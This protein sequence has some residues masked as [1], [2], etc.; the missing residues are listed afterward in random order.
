MCIT[1]G[2]KFNIKKDRGFTLIELLVAVA[3]FG[4]IGGVAVGVSI[5]GLHAQRKTLASQELLSQ[6]S[7]LMEYMSRT[8]RMAKKEL[9]ESPSCLSER[10][11]NY[12]FTSINGILG[13]KF[14]NSQG[15]CQGFFLDGDGLLK[16]W[17]EG[18]ASPLPLT[19]DDLTVNY[20]NIGP[21]DSWHQDSK[22]Q[23]RVTIFLE[24]E[25]KEQSKIKIQ[26]TISQ[27]DP[28]IIR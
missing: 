4:L 9:N 2:R 24:I 23:P 13:L 6:S 20:F 1:G 16:E 3:V 21:E 22:E 10:G 26:T 17:Q 18:Y 28:N 27:R 7:Y 11:L 8:I 14:I 19:S 12:E 25:D 15:I 5:S